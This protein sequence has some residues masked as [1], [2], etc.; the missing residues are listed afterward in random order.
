MIMIAP[1]AHTSKGLAKAFVSSAGARGRRTGTL[2]LLFLLRSE[3]LGQ[4][5]AYLSAGVLYTPALFFPYSLL[6]FLE[7]LFSEAQ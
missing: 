1:A 5:P 4:G 6:G 3:V 2:R 7:E